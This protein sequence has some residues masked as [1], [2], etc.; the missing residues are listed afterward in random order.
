MT[1]PSPPKDAEPD[2][3]ATPAQL[4]AART[5]LR[6][7]AHWLDSGIAVPGTRW[8]IGFE[9]L[10]GLVPGIGDAAGALL[11]AYF[12]AE[13]LRLRASGS[14]VMRMLG[15]VLLD[16][17]LGLVPVLGDLADFAFKSNQ[18]NLR[19]LDAHL[20]TR[21]GEPPAR[22]RAG[23]ITL[24]L[25]LAALLAWALWRLGGFTG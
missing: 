13:A 10:I 2:G 19:L 20:A 11:G 3:A 17:L 23:W 25:L 9:A 24:A 22:H 18:R 15:N 4:Q 6:R 5:R 14:L 21:L 12:V 7:L 8:R 16:A 1:D